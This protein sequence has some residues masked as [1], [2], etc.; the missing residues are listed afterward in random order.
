MFDVTSLSENYK[1]RL[2]TASDAES[3]YELE[4]G[5]PLY[6]EFCPPAASLQGVLDDMKALPPRTTYDDKYY[7]GYFDGDQLVAVMDLIFDYPNDTTAFIGFFMMRKENQGKK[8]GSKIISE[9][10]QAIRRQGYSSI[11]LG[12]MKGNR[13][14]EAFWRKNGFTPTGIEIE[15]GQGTVVYME[16]RVP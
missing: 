15:N 14:S 3:I 13:Q 10:F 2:L 9:C 7:L 16:K 6:F 12:F 5:N 11:R 4:L 1:V 8:I